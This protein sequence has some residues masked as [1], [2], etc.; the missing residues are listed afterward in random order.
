MQKWGEYSEFQQIYSKRPE[1]TGE[2]QSCSII[3]STDPS[4][5]VG[6]TFLKVRASIMVCFLKSTPPS[7]KGKSEYCVNECDGERNELR[8]F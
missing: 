7:F 2:R 4:S 6:I 8:T 5:L 3:T 1:Y